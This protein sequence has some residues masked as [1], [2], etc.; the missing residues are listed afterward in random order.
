MV[1]IWRKL[2]FMTKS[3][4]TTI[5]IVAIVLLL[6]ACG[7][8]E[9]PAKGPQ[10]ENGVLDLTN[11]DL[12]RNGPVQLSGEW[13]FYWEQLLTPDDFAGTS[14][15]PRTGLIELPAPW[16]GYV[17]DGEPISGD[18]Y[19]TYRLR[20]L[21]SGSDASSLALQVPEFE[22]AFVLYID[23]REIGSNGV[24]GKTPE[25]MR[26]QW[27][28]QVADF[29][30]QDQLE[31]ILQIS[32]FYHRKG[33]AGQVIQLGTEEQIRRIREANLNY[34]LFLFGSIF[35][36]GFYH[37]VLFVLRRK[38]RSPLYFGIC[39][40]L[41]SVRVL[42][43]GEYFLSSYLP[44]IDWE[45]LLRLNYLS[46]GLTPPV[47]AM[48]MRVLFPKEISRWSLRILELVG[49]V[50]AA[51]VL[52]APARIFTHALPPYQVSILVLSVYFLGVVVW[53]AVR[54]REG[55]VIFLLCFLVLLLAMTN[56][57]LHNNQI[58]RTGYFGP[59]GIFIFILAQGILLARRF[60]KA[61]L[62]VETLSGELEQRVVER[63]EELSFS[64]ERLKQVNLDLEQEII[65][66][67]RDQETLRNYA[68]RLRTMHEIDQSILTARS[69]ETIAVAAISRIRHLVLCQRVIVM[70]VAEAC[71]AEKL[72]AESSGEIALSPN[73]DIY[74]E[75][76]EMQSLREGL[77]QGVEDLAA[78]HGRSPMQ[79]ALYLEGVR[80]YVVVPMRVRDELIGT[81]HLEANRPKA[82]TAD[83]INSAMEIAVLLAVGIRQARLYEQAQRE[84][85][86]RKQAEAS[87]RQ[88]TLELEERNAELDA[89]AHTVA[90]DLKNPLTSLIGFSDLLEG[91]FHRMSEELVRSNL[92]F[93]KQS[94]R[95]M[96]SII[97]ELLLLSS[98]RAMEEIETEPLDIAYLV[99]E[100]QERLA[101]LIDEHQ[102]EIILPDQWPVAQG[103]AAR[104][105]EVWANYLSNAIKYGGRPLCIEL[106]A[107]SQ[108]DGFV[109]FWVR[110]NGPGLSPEQQARLFSPFERLGEVRTQGHG[111]GL[112]IVL[113]IVEKLGGQVGVESEVGQ[114]SEFFFTLPS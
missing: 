62:E 2:D 13:E 43:T 14:L 98:V 94:G 55:A 12:V 19:A 38:D 107:T 29:L 92:E 39:C 73:V 102:P 68:D 111:L 80:S 97:D 113:R 53:A 20:V 86:E 30:A 3:G 101:H 9:S 22:T 109:R 83:H 95:K 91:R 63:T 99:A 57:I 50:F 71:P 104:I 56:D 84:I 24:V 114:G 70:E 23:G 89:F 51:V 34:E 17:V 27:L 26:P 47:F 78:H 44:G 8:V 5:A 74:C 69:A 42:V 60:S 21:L 54:R 87:L 10:A 105:E 16:N 108:Q 4:V 100:V 67:Q 35:I 28:P 79:Q 93:I 76:F 59:L 106:G 37:L 48:F 58:I 1:A 64:N 61:F 25:T 40:F 49:G 65:E 75:M 85:A 7:R 18:G 33:G 103:Y 32:N 46:F 45:F 36:M 112:S 82:F 31:I 72:A 77:V 41:M 88:R 66:R 6:T 96:E 110:D 81:L 90:H 11:W 52:F 15:P